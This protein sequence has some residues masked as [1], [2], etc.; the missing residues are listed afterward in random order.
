MKLTIRRCY[1]GNPHIGQAVPWRVAAWWAVLRV[2]TPE[3]VEGQ[4]IRGRSEPDLIRQAGKIAEQTPGGVRARLDITPI[5]YIPR[6][7]AVGVG[8]TEVCRFGVGVRSHAETLR[9]KAAV[10]A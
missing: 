8:D 9:R 10:A 4:Q 7:R 2:W 1:G 6:W 3:G 5:P